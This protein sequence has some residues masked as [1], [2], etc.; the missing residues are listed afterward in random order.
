MKQIYNKVVSWLTAHIDKVLHFT[1]CA[2]LTLY[3]ALVDFGLALF[4]PIFVGVCKEII[5]AGLASRAWKKAHPDATLEEQSAQRF[6][7]WGDLIAD[8]L[9]I[10]VVAVPLYFIMF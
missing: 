7:C 5:D 9:G 3:G 1:V 6:F 2:L 10:I 4:L 8:F